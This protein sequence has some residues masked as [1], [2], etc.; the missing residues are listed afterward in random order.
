MPGQPNSRKMRF[1]ARHIE[2]RGHDH[3]LSVVEVS[4]DRKELKIEPFTQETHSTSYIPGKVIITEKDG[5][6]EIFAE[7]S[8]KY[9]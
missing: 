9:L 3:G 8:G 1:L 7:Y 4:D 6:Y 5:K 2:Y